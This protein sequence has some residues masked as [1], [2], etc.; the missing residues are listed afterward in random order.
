[1]TIRINKFEL[2]PI[3]SINAENITENAFQGTNSDKYT[4]ITEQ[5]KS[6]LLNEKEATSTQQLCIDISDIFF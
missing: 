6:E 2:K 4:E 1:M 3:Q 5:L